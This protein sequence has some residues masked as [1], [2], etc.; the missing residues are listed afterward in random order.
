MGTPAMTTR[1]FEPEDFRRVADIVHRAVVITQS[2][3]KAAIEGDSKSLKAFNKFVGEGQ[4]FSDI[5]QLRK[6]VEDW[7]ATF[8]VPWD[9]TK[10]F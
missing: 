2:V 9:T 4:N 6:E 3:N 8:S 7:V 1:G 10:K 5:V